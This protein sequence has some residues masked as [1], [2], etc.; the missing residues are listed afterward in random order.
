[1]VHPQVDH[2]D[3]HPVAQ[4]H[5]EGRGRGARLAV[6]GQ[7]VEL[8]RE[9]VGHGVVGEDRPFLNDEPKVLVHPRPVGFL[10]VQDEEAD[11]PH[12]LL[13]RHV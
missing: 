9:A 7:P 6:D 10:G 2:P 8:H 1:M 12:H 5:D 13:H 11:H 3:A 4:P